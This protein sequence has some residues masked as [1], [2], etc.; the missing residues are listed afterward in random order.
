[1][2]T[3]GRLP[4][5]MMNSSAIAARARL[6]SS[7]TARLSTRSTS[8]PASRP[9]V[10]AGSVKESTRPLTAVFEPVCL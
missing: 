10:S 9:I 8:T 3:L 1:M 5:E 7:S 4:V 6:V 2:K